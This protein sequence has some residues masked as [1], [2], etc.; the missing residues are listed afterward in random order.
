MGGEMNR[1]DIAA[2]IEE[3]QEQSQ[4]RLSV[5]AQADAVWANLQGQV[6]AYNE[7]LGSIEEDLK[8]DPKKQGAK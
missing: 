2:K 8:S 6:S 5:L 1:E 4:Q 3:L 7:M